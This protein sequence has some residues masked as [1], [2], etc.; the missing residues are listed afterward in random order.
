MARTPIRRHP[1]FLYRA[2]PYLLCMSATPRLL[3][4][5]NSHE[6]SDELTTVH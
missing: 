4:A 2:W 1:T 6:H 3:K 5:T